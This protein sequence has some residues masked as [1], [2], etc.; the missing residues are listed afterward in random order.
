MPKQLNDKRAVFQK[1][2]QHAFLQRAKD[3]LGL[4]WSEF[5]KRIGVHRRVMSDWQREQ[6]S[7]PQR[8]ADQI[9]RSFNIPIPETVEYRERFWYTSKGGKIAGPL[10]YKKYGHIGGDPETRK[11][12]WLEWWKKH[13]INNLGELAVE[14]KINIPKL[15]P[16]LAEF[17]GIILGD[18]GITN[19]QVV[20]SLDSQNDRAYA[21]FVVN[22]FYKLFGVHASI[23]YRKTSR[24]LDIVVSRTALVSFCASI[25]LLE[26]NKVKRQ[27]DIPAW[28]MA[29]AHF[30]KACVR[31][32]MDTDGS[33]FNECHLIGGKRYSYPRLWF[34]SHS[35]PLR[36]SVCKTL[37]IA[38]FSPKIRRDRAVTLE[39][40]SD[41]IR[42]FS[43]IGTSNPKHRERFE[44]ITGRVG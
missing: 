30:R 13:A 9:S 5:A 43:F 25:G 19:R 11:E 27:A 33:I 41:V 22:L 34:V 24:C 12:K 40:P 26:G 39:K 15:S 7:L 16:L 8:V 32:L 29:Q 31:G 42:Y 18:G 4:S 17:A 6:F 21:E 2:E 14:R 38:G 44:R 3:P 23:R 28:I 37:E 35:K 36:E 20:V 1:G 10:M